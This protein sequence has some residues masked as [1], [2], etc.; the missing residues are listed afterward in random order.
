MERERIYILCI[1]LVLL[2]YAYIFGKHNAFANVLISIGAIG[3]L[4][5]LFLV[6]NVYTKEDKRDRFEELKLSTIKDKLLIHQSISWL[7]YDDFLSSVIIDLYPVIRYDIDVLKTV[8]IDINK[9]LKI[10]YTSMSSKDNS[11]LLY[12][13]IRKNQTTIQSLEDKKTDILDELMNLVYVLPTN[14]FYVESNIPQV[15]SLIHDYFDQKIHLLSTKLKMKQ[16]K[17]ASASL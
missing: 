12:K 14:M 7:E 4:Y 15:C 1:V 11:V 13:N 5:K 16:T 6:F 9:F 2:M 3:C 8:M 17:F 10:Y